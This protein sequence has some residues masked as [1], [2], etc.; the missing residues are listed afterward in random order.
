VVAP[1]GVTRDSFWERITAGETSTRRITFFD[2]SGFRSQM[3]AE[4]DFDPHE[5]G[6]TEHEVRRMD[7]YIQFA[8]AAGT[9]AIADS[10]LD[11]EDVDRERMAV[12]LGSAV[13]GTMALE[14]GY[15]AVSN[16]GQDWLVDPDYA[17]PFVYQGLVPSSLASEIALK[18][19]AQGPSVVVS[20]G[21]TSGIDAIGYGH[22][23]IQDGEADIVISGA[24]ESPISPISMACF[25]P[26]KATSPHNDDPEHASKPFDRDRAGF[27]MGEGGAVLILEEY[28][29]A[30]ARGAHVYCEVAGYAT[31]G[32]AYHMTGLRKEAYAMTE[33]IKDAMRQAD[34][35]PE[36][37]DYIN[38]HGSGT[39]QNDRHETQAYKNCL[40]DHAYKVPVSSIKS[41][42]GHSLG[43]IGAIE[44]AAC[45]LAIDRDMVPPTAN[46]VNPDPEC[47]LD[48]TPG[49]ARAKPVFTAL[50][51]GSGFGG[52]QSAMIFSV[53]E[54][55]REVS[56]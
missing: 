7:R 46:L 23:L 48:Y 30:R 56:A 3:A 10:A 43:A 39:K 54:E 4:A 25:D 34:A 31:R 44:M 5:A 35:R 16:R 15:V 2:P 17:P 41:M 53:P 28:E 52:F 32:N 42:I 37:F 6:L 12:T 26:I 11:L 51:T 50:S 27:V 1:G 29:L 19:G 21:C 8:A 18:F 45:A 47:D 9:E 40:G 13:G 20:T 36:D 24:S 49:Q 55:L 38:A 33:A 14:D 22:Q